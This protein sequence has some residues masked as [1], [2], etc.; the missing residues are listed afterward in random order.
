M[1]LL[2]WLLGCRAAAIVLS[3]NPLPA[4]YLHAPV[5][6]LTCLLKPL[7]CSSTPL[8]CFLPSLPARACRALWNLRK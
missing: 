1:A 7:T 4:C 8:P 6:P 5:E 3:S 2:V